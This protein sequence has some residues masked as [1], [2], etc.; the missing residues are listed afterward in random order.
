MARTASRS[1]KGNEMRNVVPCVAA[2]A[3]GAALAGGSAAGAAERYVADLRPLNADVAGHEATGEATFEI[4]DGQ[5]T[6]T[7]EAKG[8]EP[9][10]AHLQHFHGFPDGSDATRP[11]MAADANGDGIID[12]IETQPS[13]GTTMVPFHADPVSLEIPSKTYP[14]AAADGRT[15]YHATVALADLEQALSKKFGAKALA[16]EQRV[17]IVHGVAPATKLPDSVASLETVPAQ[18]TLPVACGEI[19]RAE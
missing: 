1:K 12:L 17:M 11:T 15:S 9:G 5:L 4:A 19:R 7:V 6:I 18:I 8:L 14:V 2:V 10:I 16:L 3:L 13:A